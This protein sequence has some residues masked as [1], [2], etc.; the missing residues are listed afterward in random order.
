MHSLYFCYFIWIKMITKTT[1]CLAYWFD[2]FVDLNGDLLGDL[3]LTIIELT[4]WPCVCV[5]QP[6][7]RT[8]MSPSPKSQVMFA[9][10]FSR[11]GIFFRIFGI[12]TFY[13]TATLLCMNMH[14]M[15][16]CSGRWLWGRIGF[17]ISRMQNGI[18]N[19]AGWSKQIFF[20]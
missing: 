5:W 3:H 11:I 6:T 20:I 13:A 16:L 15:N 7:P 19:M 18:Q 17:C 2:V 9:S 14:A 10:A 1:H 4:V 12:H 8:L